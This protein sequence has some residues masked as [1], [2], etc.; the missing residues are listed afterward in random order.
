MTI[1]FL[2]YLIARIMENAV[3]A[4]AELKEDMKSE[5]KS[6]KRLAYYE[7]LDI[8]KSEADVE[9]LDLKE[10]GLGIDLDKEL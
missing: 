8:I 2:K 3:E 4:S 7:V 1:E 5:F 6:G 10:L 9:G